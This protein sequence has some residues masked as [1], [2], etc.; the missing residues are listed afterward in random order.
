MPLQVVL[1]AVLINLRFVNGLLTADHCND[2][3]CPN[4]SLL[5]CELNE[6]QLCETLCIGHLYFDCC[7][8]V[9]WIQFLPCVSD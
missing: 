7:F 8:N 9:Q 6:N 2:L 5:M 3:L 4:E 1:I